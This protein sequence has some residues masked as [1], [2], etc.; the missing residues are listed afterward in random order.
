MFILMVKIEVFVAFDVT[1]TTPV[2][3]HVPTFNVIGAYV[4]VADVIAIVPE[5]DS[6]AFM[7]YPNCPV[8]GATVSLFNVTF[9]ER[10]RHVFGV[11]VPDAGL[12]GQ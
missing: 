2:I 8:V 9:E 11:V 12:P 6:V 4:V 5:V 3:N 10:T 7:V 1:F